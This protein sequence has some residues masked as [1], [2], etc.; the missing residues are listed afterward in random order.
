[1]ISALVYLLFFLLLGLIIY[2]DAEK[3][4]ISFIIG[5]ILFPTT[6]LF[7]KNPSISPQHIFLYTFL[8]IEISKDFRNFKQSLFH[9]PLRIPLFLI[10]LSYICSAAANSGIASKELY[11][12]A[13]DFLDTFGYVLTAFII[14][15]KIDLESF[16][17]KMY[18]PII[19]VCIFGIIEGLLNTNIPYKIINSAFPIYEGYYSLNTDIS[20]RQDWRIRTC[21]TTKHPTAFGILLTTFFLFY[22]PYIKS[23]FF[24][25]IKIYL[26]LSLVGVNIFL[27]G[28]R[29]ALCCIFIG[30]FIYVLNQFSLK[31]R[32]L[33][34]GFILI[35]LS[36]ILAYMIATFNYSSGS[37]LNFRQKQFIFSY[38]TVQKA[39]LFG[40]GNKFTANYILQE[41]D[42]GNGKKAQDSSGENMGGLESIVFSLLIDRGFVGL[43]GYY[44]FLITFLILLYRKRHSEYAENGYVLILS[45]SLFL[46]LSGTIGNSSAFFF[47]FSGL[48]LGHVYQEDDLQEIEDTSVET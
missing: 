22:L 18:W 24:P 39:P 23:N 31:F 1:M 40:N 16:V 32:I 10:L 42:N 8:F 34:Y 43:I 19:I 17:Q 3:R 20:L 6:A 36:S 27:C 11:Y 37:S 21:F 44:L 30:I 35:S 46:T 5:T 29:T 45:G 7:I 13:R 48:L 9:N 14:G 2:G 47:L 4:F 12:G 15:K 26:L 38:L 41:T 28:S 25:K 33:V